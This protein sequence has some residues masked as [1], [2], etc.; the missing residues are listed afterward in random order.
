VSNQIWGADLCRAAAELLGHANGFDD[1]ASTSPLEPEDFEV[2]CPKCLEDTADPY[3]GRGKW[4]DDNLVDECAAEEAAKA[5]RRLTAWKRK[6]DWKPHPPSHVTTERPD[7]NS[8][9]SIPSVRN[10]NV[11]PRSLP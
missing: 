5:E 10:Y 2:T 11:P 4:A 1:C 7:W 8:R 6:R 9:I 3:A